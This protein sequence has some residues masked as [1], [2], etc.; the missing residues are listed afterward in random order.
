[1]HLLDVTQLAALKGIGKIKPLKL[2]LKSP[3]YCD[4]LKQLGED[5]NLN[6]DLISGCEKFTCTLCGKAKYES[7]DEVRHIMLK[8][9]CDGDI[10]LQSLKSTTIDLAKLPPSRACLREHIARANYQTRIWKTG[11]VAISEVP[12]PCDGYGWLENGEPLWCDKDMILPQTI[13]DVLDREATDP[14][15]SDDETQDLEYG[16]DSDD[17]SSDED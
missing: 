9:K 6:E 14:E 7:I 17:S 10:T 3:A 1:M 2:L 13:I 16:V 4:I 11:N 12:K 8:S 15:D 5:W